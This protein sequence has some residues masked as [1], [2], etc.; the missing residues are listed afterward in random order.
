MNKSRAQE[1]T[2]F[3]RSIRNEWGWDPLAI[4]EKA[5]IKIFEHNTGRSPSA[6]IM[7]TGENYPVLITLT[8][9]TNDRQRYVLCAHE[10]GHYFLHSE[11][12][13]NKFDG[14]KVDT[15][16]EANLFAV[17]LLCDDSQFIQ[18][19]AK[20]PGSVLKGILDYNLK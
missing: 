12:G 14:N 9:C 4:A 3:A 19:V 8:D 16:Y 13:L 11:C 20:F 5:G 6:Y 17:A 15:E 10:L 18:P 1:I 7:K 2:K